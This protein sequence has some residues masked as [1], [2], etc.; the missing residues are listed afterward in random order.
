MKKEKKL[1]HLS[2]K[3]QKDYNLIIRA[4]EEKDQQAFSELMDKYKDPIYF[5]L[6]KMVNNNDDA[7]DLTL[8]AF[9]KAFNRL[10]QYTP[11]FAFSTWLFKIATNNCIDFLRK[12]KKN[13]MS[14]D[15]RVSNKDGEEYMFEIKSEGMTPEQIAMNDQKIQLMRQYVK[16]LKPRY[17]TLVEMRYFKELSYDEISEEMKLPLGTVKA[18]L[19]RAREFLYN[20]MK[21]SIETI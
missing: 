15:N 5:M 9:G 1:S 8:E 16:K 13:V 11:N 14:I 2:E 4:T 19:F 7:E 20:I 12:K 21:H 6:L 17:Q 10:N 18:Q 3:A